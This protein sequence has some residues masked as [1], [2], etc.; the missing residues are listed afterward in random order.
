[1]SESN[2][3]GSPKVQSAYAARGWQ[4]PNQ[5][6]ATISMILGILSL[7]SFL[8]GCCCGPL[9]LVI[10]PLAIGAVVCGH[11]AKSRIRK[12]T[13]AGDGM[14][15]AGLIC[16]YVAL[17][18]FCA[19]IIFYVILMLN[20]DVNQQGASIPKAASVLRTR[21]VIDLAELLTW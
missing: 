20:M 11:M 1:M 10:P 12:G 2:P 6:L 4:P 18:L 17:A 19:A 21:E 8:V 14:A 13:D 3:Y 5:N 7:C 9:A 15:L 16:G